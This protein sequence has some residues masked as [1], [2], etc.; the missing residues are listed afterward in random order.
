MKNIVVSL[1]LLAFVFEADSCLYRAM[2]DG[3][4]QIIT[5]SYNGARSKKAI[6]FLREAGATVADSYQVSVIDY[7]MPFDTTSVG[8]A[9]T[10]DDN[11][12]KADFSGG[13]IKLKW[14]SDDTLKINYNKKL[15]TF[16]QQNKVDN[17]VIVYQTE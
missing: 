4:D 14:I 6:L 13:A 12:G 11:H 17:V 15:R 3:A 10:A 9:F 16:I 2:S 7:D 1:M 8:N 5:E